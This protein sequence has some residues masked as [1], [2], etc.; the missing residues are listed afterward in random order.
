MSLTILQE[1]HRETR[2]L[3]IAGSKLARGDL[4]LGKLLPSLQKLGESSPVFA[5]IAQAVEL[6]LNAEPEQADVRLLDL[7]ALLQSVLHTQGST[8][9]PGKLE[10][11]EGADS[12]DYAFQ[13]YRK[14]KPVIEALTEKGQG[15]L[16]VLRQASEEGLM[17]DYRLLIPAVAALDDA[18]AEIPELMEN[19][20]LPAFVKGAVPVLLSR[21]RPEGGRGDSRRLRLIH[22]QLGESAKPLLAQA[23]EQGSP[24]V[25]S[26]AVELLGHYADQEDFLLRLADDKRKEVRRAALLGLARIGTPEASDRIF[27]ALVSKDRD[28]AVEPI[29]KSDDAG[30]ILRTVDYARSVRSAE[31]K[32]TESDWGP[33]EVS[34][35][36]LIGRH[37]EETYELL[38]DLLSD[39]P[40]IG[41]RPVA[42]SPAV[43]DFARGYA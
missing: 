23:A 4:K 40:A 21:F 25:R 39:P 22:G 43:R 26:A 35:N 38:K 10:P 15:R 36:A 19:K 42:G 27:A 33:L 17:K 31:G 9:V 16:E 14:L 3:F 6:T 12:F 18:Y 37:T 8:D 32:K 11:L 30:L 24:E 20:V 2:R 7:N 34:L 28:S 41:R 1:L 13:P 5:R 29:R